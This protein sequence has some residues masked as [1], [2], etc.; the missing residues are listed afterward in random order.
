[1]KIIKTK[2]Q[3][4]PILRF[5]I[6]SN[7]RE[8]SRYFKINHETNRFAFKRYYPFIYKNKDSLIINKIFLLTKEQGSF[9]I[10]VDSQKVMFSNSW[11]YFVSKFSVYHNGN[12]YFLFK[13]G[14]CHRIIMNAADHMEVDHINRK[15]FDNREENLRICNKNQ[16][17]GNK[18][19]AGVFKEKR[20]LTK[21]I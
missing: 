17:H 7:I 4:K 12:G 10:N 16:N 21:K 20:S 5:I 1:M 11:K 3:F 9:S 6:H 18:K 15:K 14:Y 8:A 19:A 2:D 13:W